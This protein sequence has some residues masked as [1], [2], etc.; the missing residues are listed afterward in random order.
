MAGI[1]GDDQKYCGNCKRDIAAVNFVMHDVH[2]RRNILLCSVCDEP[3]A[4]SELDDHMSE[5]HTHCP[6]CNK[7]ASTYLGTVFAFSIF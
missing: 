5:E 3:V 7:Q 4:R 1:G 2:C 6:E